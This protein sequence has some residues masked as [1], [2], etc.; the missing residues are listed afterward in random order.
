MSKKTDL[1]V[2]IDYIQNQLGGVI[3]STYANPYGQ[4]RITIMEE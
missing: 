1:Q 4:G 2:T 3:G